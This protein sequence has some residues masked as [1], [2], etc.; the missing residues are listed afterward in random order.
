MENFE[1]FTIITFK[2]V[3]FEGT[4]EEVVILL[5]E[6]KSNK[7]GIEVVELEDASELISKKK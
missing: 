2:K 1:H 5:G 3:L 6:K 4:Q 7:K